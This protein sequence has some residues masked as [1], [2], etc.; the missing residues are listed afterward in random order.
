MATLLPLFVTDNI[1]I[2]ELTK[3]VIYAPYTE[4]PLIRAGLSLVVL[5]LFSLLWIIGFRFRDISW[6]A[7]GSAAVLAQNLAAYGQT[8][9]LNF[10][11]AFD[12]VEAVSNVITAFAVP[13]ALA[14]FMRYKTPSNRVRF[15]YLGLMTVLCVVVAF[16]SLST[17]RQFMMLR[18]FQAAIGILLNLGLLVWTFK[19]F[20]MHKRDQK[21]RSRILVVQALCISWII[22]GAAQFLLEKR[23]GVGLSPYGNLLAILAIACFVVFDLV[24]KHRAHA[25]ERRLRLAVEGDLWQARAVAKTA[26]LLGHDIARPFLILANVQKCLEAQS[27]H[28]TLTV[29][30]AVAS[31]F[32]KAYGFFRNLL[33][34]LRTLGDS[35][36]ARSEVIVLRSLIEEVTELVFLGREDQKCSILIDIDEAE[37]VSGVRT[38]LVRA[39][40]NLIENA[41]DASAGLSGSIEIRSKIESGFIRIAV[42]NSG[43]FIPE[44][45]RDKVFEFGFTSGKLG[46]SGLGLA[47]VKKIAEDH[48]GSVRCWSSDDQV[49]TFELMLPHKQISKELSSPQDDA[50]KRR[51]VVGIVDDDEFLTLL[52]KSYL[53]QYEVVTW[54]HPEL[55]LQEAKSKP[56]WIDLFILDMNFTNHTMMGVDVARN[57]RLCGYKGPIILA[58]SQTP[59]LSAEDAALFAKIMSK[60]APDLSNALEDIL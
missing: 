44:Y 22:F 58:S 57:L 16:V 49:T 46:G 60:H 19:I 31:D 2:F 45:L 24:T 10:A 41:R 8:F 35:K 39:L 37:K 51:A 26:Q 20:S 43:S 56:E 13:A 48:C 38:L 54:S 52:L 17:F 42:I 29:P 25:E 30:A 5:I 32:S 59:S 33:D 27:S 36:A 53:S 12:R 9:F 23:L 55:C 40:F 3:R 50:P 47:L 18:Q 7:F 4:H 6:V 34:Q 14:E 11:D 21:L 1:Q 15:T 28:S